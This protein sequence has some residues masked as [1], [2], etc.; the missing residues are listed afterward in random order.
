[1]AFAPIDKMRLDH[2]GLAGLGTNASTDGKEDTSTSDKPEKG[3][4]A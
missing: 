3:G 2:S 4:E 1:M